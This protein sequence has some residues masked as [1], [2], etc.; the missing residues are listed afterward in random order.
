MYDILVNAGWLSSSGTCKDTIQTSVKM[1]IT[2]IPYLN[3]H[4]VIKITLL[5]PHA[6][7]SV[8][9]SQSSDRVKNDLCEQTA[10]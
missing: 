9:N 2:A 10:A 3:D 6:A 4:L 5:S 8:L 1:C 7:K